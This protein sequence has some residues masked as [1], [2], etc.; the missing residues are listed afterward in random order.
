[1]GFFLLLFLLIV[2]GKWP[3]RWAILFPGAS[4]NL[5]S[6]EKILEIRLGA[7]VFNRSSMTL[8]SLIWRAAKAAP[9]NY[10]ATSLGLL[11]FIMNLNG[12]G[13]ERM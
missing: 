1:M 6:K 9:T 3:S 5:C 11:D 2:A 10:L 4:L 13:R 12:C 8:Y 7:P